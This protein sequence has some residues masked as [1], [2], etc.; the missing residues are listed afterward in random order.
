MFAME[1][2]GD[3][4]I[5]TVVERYFDFLCVGIA[6]LIHCLNPEIVILGGGISAEGRRLCD[7]V[8][9]RLKEMVMPGFLKDLTVCTAQYQNDAGMLGA[10]ELYY[11]TNFSG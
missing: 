6:D 11:G 3:A 7:R 8:M 9:L 10:A 2:S 4:G 5:H 1:R